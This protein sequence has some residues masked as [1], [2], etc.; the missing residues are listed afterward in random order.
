METEVARAEKLLA[1]RKKLKK[2][3]MKKE[4]PRSRTPSLASV[5]SAGT[6]DDLTLNHT[7]PPSLATSHP[8]LLSHHHPSPGLDAKLEPINPAPPSI[9]EYG[10]RASD[11]C[12]MLPPSP[13]AYPAGT[14]REWG[15]LPIEID[16]NRERT[17]E[18]MSKDLE[19]EM[20]RLRYELENSLRKQEESEKHHLLEKS[21]LENQLNVQTETITRLRRDVSNAELR[22]AQNE[23]ELASLTQVHQQEKSRLTHQLSDLNAI[24]DQLREHHA[25]AEQLIAR[26]DEELAAL[27]LQISESENRL[28]EMTEATEKM[29]ALRGAVD[30][31]REENVALAVQIQETMASM[32][33]KENLI[34]ELTS[35]RDSLQS[36][37]DSAQMSTAKLAREVANAGDHIERLEMENQRLQAEAEKWREKGERVGETLQMVEEKLQKEQERAALLERELHEQREDNAGACTHRGIVLPIQKKGVPLLEL[38]HGT[39]ER[40][41]TADQD[42][43]KERAHVY[44]QLLAEREKRSEV[45]QRLDI[46]RST[47]EAMEEEFRVV[48]RANRDLSRQLLEARSSSASSSNGS[49]GGANMPGS[50]NG[51]SM[52][53][54]KRPAL[55]A[56]GLIS[57]VSSRYSSHAKSRMSM[58]IIPAHQIAAYAS[59]SGHQR[60]A[61]MSMHQPQNPLTPTGNKDPFEEQKRLRRSSSSNVSQ[62]YMMGGRRSIGSQSYVSHR[63]SFST[64]PSQPSSPLPL[65]PTS[66]TT[67]P[68]FASSHAGTAQ[69]M[70]PSSLYQ[71]RQSQMRRM[72]TDP[73]LASSLQSASAQNHSPPRSA[74]LSTASPH[75]LGAS[76]DLGLGLNLVK[77]TGVPRCAGCSAQVIE[78]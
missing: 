61:S 70:T 31:L 36:N 39:P 37:L 62:N 21:H 42:A 71:M 49:L 78:I 18:D 60:G 44:S 35:E 56:G 74:P 17:M 75:R 10:S 2:F 68:N 33:K 76:P 67:T 14:R 11:D 30:G 66:A 58:P 4:E 53:A 7:S 45:E 25:S 46:L 69:G 72:A 24:A 29:Q 57:G 64:S 65:S 16:P 19:R 12:R 22:L 9:R 54:D 32:A 15:Q 59:A 38:S 48:V 55:G 20:A 23:Q 51:N 8:P 43:E 73:Y 52:G 47:Y 3:Q 28:A 50:G 6:A 5:S 77:N 13:P 41:P 40:K 63:T 34:A 26:R 1:A 27:R